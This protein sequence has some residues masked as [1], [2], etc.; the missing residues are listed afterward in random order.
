MLRTSEFDRQVLER[1]QQG[2]ERAFADFVRHHAG[3]VHRVLAR[4]LVGID[5]TDLDD[6]AQVTFLKAHRAL[7][8]YQ[9]RSA[10]SLRAWVV[11]I[12]T[13]VA[14]DVLRTGRSSDAPFVDDRTASSTASTDALL[15]ARELG[16]ALAAAVARLSPERRAVFVLYEYE[17]LD[18]GE[19]AQSLA[20]DRGTVKSRLS[21]ARAQL[22][23]HLR[24]HGHG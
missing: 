7:P 5:P 13:R 23:D 14:L 4:L 16:A 20:I 18:Y 21:R 3:I 10:R 1:A 6:L 2:D 17:G 15:G 11:T 19:I 22:R 12:A 24:R 9:M 8:R